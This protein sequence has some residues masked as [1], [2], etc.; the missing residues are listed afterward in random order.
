MVCSLLSKTFNFN[1]LLRFKMNSSA[2]GIFSLFIN[3]HAQNIGTLESIKILVS[4]FAK[5]VCMEVLIL[6]S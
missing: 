5:K 1:H 3:V 6:Q 4:I 2:H